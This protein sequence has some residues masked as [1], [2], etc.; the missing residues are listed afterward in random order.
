MANASNAMAGNTVAHSETVA[1]P[2]YDEVMEHAH[3]AHPA[4]ACGL[5][6]RLHAGGQLVYRRAVNVAAD[7]LTGF[8]VAPRDWAS[9]EDVGVV[10]A[11]VHSHP[12]ASA[13]PSD[14][15]RHGCHASGVAWFVVACP[16]GQVRKIEPEP[17]E[18][19]GREFTHGVVD[20]YTL[21]RDYFR[22]RCGIELADYKRDDDWWVRGADLYRQNFEAAGFVCLGNGQSVVPRE[23][24]ALLMQISS[25]VP[26][27]AGVYIGGQQFIHHLYNRLSERAVWGGYWMRHCTHVLRHRSRM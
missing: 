20:C 19:V 18:L 23:H 5:L 22:T 25:P 26:N 10:E 14:V 13:A 4:E 12:N 2:L 9:A 11:V 6:V 15:D 17:L 8:E 1:L 21:V 3:D 27:H 16:G 7:P 24:D